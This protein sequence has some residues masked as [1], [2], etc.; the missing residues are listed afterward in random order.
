MDWGAFMWMLMPFV[1]KNELPTYQEILN[2][3]FKEYLNYF[4]KIFLDDFIVY[5]DVDTRLSKFRLFFFKC[6]EY[7]INLNLKK[8]T[9]I[10]FSNLIFKFIIVK[11]EKLLD[12]KKIYA[13]MNI[14]V[15]TNP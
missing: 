4:M 10:V 15:S 8:C 11:E 12:P 14:P 13:L 9:F 5:N 1:V 2:Q 6:K 7:G 3:T